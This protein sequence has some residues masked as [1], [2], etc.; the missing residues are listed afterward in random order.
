MRWKTMM[1]IIGTAAMFIVG[2]SGQVN[3]NG[4]LSILVLMWITLGEL[5]DN[6]ER[7]AKGPK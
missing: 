5:A 3:I 6:F 2:Q 1:L 4:R 7:K